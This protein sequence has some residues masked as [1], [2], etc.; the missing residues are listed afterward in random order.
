VADTTVTRRWSPSRREFEELLDEVELPRM[1]LIEQTILSPEP[2]GDIREAVRASLRSV[3]LPTGT[4]AIGV[5]SRGVARVGEIVAALVAELRAAGAEP[6]IIPAMGSHGASTA[7]GQA[8]VLA[9]LGVDEERCG[10]PVRA[11][12]EVERV[13]ETER[14]VQVYMDRNAYAADSVIVVNRIKPHTAFRGDIE[15]GC[16]KMLAIGLGKRRGAAA[17]HAQGFGEIAR[18]FVDVARVVLAQNR[19]AFGVGILESADREPYKIVAMPPD[20]IEREEHELLKQA[21]QS[22]PRIPFDEIDVLVID[23]IGKDVSGDGADPN[24]MGRYPTPFA[25]GGPTVARMVAL[26][27]TPGSEGN[28]NGIGLFDVT[29]QR[30]VDKTDLAATYLNSLTSRVTDTVRVP[31]IAGTDKQAIS[32]AART[33]AGVEPPDVRIV[34][35]EDTLHLGRMWVSEPLLA[36]LDQ[37]PGGKVIEGP[38]EWEFDSGGELSPLGGVLAHN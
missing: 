10:A 38:T 34:R 33:C 26:D 19:L 2:I 23:R 32:A 31:M 1:A 16:M 15:S 37:V 29:T 11:T 27:L 30:L 7:E 24:V 25:T 36:L 9:H 20:S 14:G 35:I 12:M 13:G 6:F 3:T 18:N 4:V 21:W 28:A 5:G 22:M 17:T 8:Q